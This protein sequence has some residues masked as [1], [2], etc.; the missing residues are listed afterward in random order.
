MPRET[1]LAASLEK[2]GA[3]EDGT[4]Q[5]QG[6]TIFPGS[7]ITDPGMASA[8]RDAESMFSFPPNSALSNAGVIGENIVI[9][10]S[11]FGMC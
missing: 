1:T 5:T 10:S 8:D 6:K 2:R 4:S 11:G 7:F 9:S 3:I